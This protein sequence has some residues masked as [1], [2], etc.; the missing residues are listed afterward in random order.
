M[1][2]ILGTVMNRLFPVLLGF[3]AACVA[4]TGGDTG[5]AAVLSVRPSGQELKSE[6]SSFVVS[7]SKQQ[8]RMVAGLNL[9]N[10]SDRT[11]SFTWAVEWMDRAGEVLQGT[12]SDWRPLRLKAG[13]MTP[14]NIEAP[15]PSAASWRL[16]TV[17]M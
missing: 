17:E 4:P 10:C 14:V 1:D 15:H 13:A 5:S 6:L 11:I 12:P 8:G 9:K 7:T 16:I 3:L 2:A